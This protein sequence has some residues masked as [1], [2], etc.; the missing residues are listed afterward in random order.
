MA[1]TEVIRDAAVLRDVKAISLVSAGHFCSHFFQM[2]LPLLFPLLVGEFNTTYLALGLLVTLSG[3]ASS[4]TETPLGFLVDRFGARW[5]L[6]GGLVLHS[7]AIMAIG[8]ADT[9]WTILVFY[10][11]AGVANAVYHPAD[12][13]L[14]SATVDPKRLGRAFSLHT[15]VGNIGWVLVPLVMVALT[16][17]WGW[18]EALMSIGAF[19]LCVA[20]CIAT[21][22]GFLREEKH[23]RAEARAASPHAVEAPGGIKLLLSP[24]ILMAFLFFMMLAAGSGGLRTFSVSALMAIYDTPLEAAGGALTGFLIGSSA[25]ILAGGL[26][27][28]RF[29]QPQSLAMLGFFGAAVCAAIVGAAAMPI[30]AVVAF[31]TMAGF[32]SGAVQPARDLL[33][34]AITP[35]GSMG[36][37]FGFLSSGLGLG[38]ALMPPLFGWIMDKGDPRWVFYVS[39]II[40]L[41]T[42]VTVGGLGRFARAKQQ[43]EAATQA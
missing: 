40:I 30:A 34:R 9:Y 35:K 16:A 36:K 5:I 42:V 19:G 1:Q 13:S 12:Y 17:L 22:G 25:G 21:L 38:G 7:L 39:A 43:A 28:D 18:R 32:F 3:L 10:I 14:L 37:V 24:P 20:V 8:F 33:V 41:M 26:I 23:V 31:L 2:A 6:V 15:F 4:V 29:R 11:I 27:A